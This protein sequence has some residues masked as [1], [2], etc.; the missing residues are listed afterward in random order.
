[1]TTVGGHVGAVVKRSVVRTKD[2]DKAVV[3]RSQINDAGTMLRHVAHMNIDDSRAHL[4]EN[5][6]RYVEATTPPL[7]NVEGL[8]DAHIC[9]GTPTSAPWRTT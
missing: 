4:L 1:M 5:G 6:A 8:D 3:V 2:Q 7:T 9:T